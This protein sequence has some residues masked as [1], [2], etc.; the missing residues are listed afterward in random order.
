MVTPPPQNLYLGKENTRKAECNTESIALQ[1]KRTY[2]HKKGGER[3]TRFLI[4]FAWQNRGG[5]LR[6]PS[7]QRPARRSRGSAAPG[8]RVRGS[9]RERAQLG[10]GAARAWG[11]PA[12]PPHLGSRAAGTGRLRIKSAWGSPRTHTPTPAATASLR[13]LG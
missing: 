2:E 12:L 5:A 11:E 8:I 13:L 10:T 6:S 7:R 3:E 4:F 1:I 9:R